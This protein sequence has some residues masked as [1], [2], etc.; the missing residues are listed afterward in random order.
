[1]I[2]VGYMAKRVRVRLESLNA[3]RVNDIY[4]VS[5]CISKDFTDYIGHWKHNGYW[6]FDTP[7]TLWKLAGDNRIDLTGTVLF[8]YEVHDLQFDDTAGQWAAFK[9]DPSFTTRVTVPQRKVLV[10]YDVLTF[11]V[12]TSAECSPLSCNALA[13]EVET[14]EHRL[15]A[16]L[17]HARHL[18]E[19]GKF[20]NT[21]L[22]PYRI[23]AV[24]SLDWPRY[25]P[26]V[27]VRDGRA[28]PCPP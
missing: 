28:A 11:S 9:P 8:F 20:K 21:E 3:G 10:G 19:N 13:V 27:N 14:N 1:M 7:E 16:S 15:L 26:A 24:Y 12:G 4:S 25:P 6:F 22:G 17:E 18:L 2:P 23:V 5:N